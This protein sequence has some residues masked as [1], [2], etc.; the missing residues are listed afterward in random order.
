MHN[1]IK[2]FEECKKELLKQNLSP[3]EYERQVKRIAKK[4]GI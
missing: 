3:K 2:R 4:F 1:N